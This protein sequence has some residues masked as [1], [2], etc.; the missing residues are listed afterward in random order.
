[1]NHLSTQGVCFFPDVNECEEEIN[2]C[3][4]NSLCINTDG[5]YECKCKDGYRGNGGMC[6]GNKG[7][8]RKGQGRREIE[9]EGK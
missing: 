6:A 2:G 3:E 5:S 9:G 4:E 1:M 7:L 8:D